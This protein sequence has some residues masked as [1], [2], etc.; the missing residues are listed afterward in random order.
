ML[1]I[2]QVIVAFGIITINEYFCFGIPGDKG[3][4]LGI[5]NPATIATI[6]EIP[7]AKA[8]Y[9]TKLSTSLDPSNVKITSIASDEKNKNVFFAIQN[10]ICVFQNFNIWQNESKAI[11]LSLAY[12]GKSAAFGQI[13]FDFVSNNLYWCDSLLNWIAMK[14][15]YGNDSIHRIVVQDDLYQPEGLA[16]DPEDGLMFFSDNDINPRIEKASMNGENRTVIVHTSIIQILALSVDTANDL[17]YWA[18]H[19]RQTVEVSHYDGSNRRVLRRNN[20]VSLTGI[21]YH[22][23]ILHAA[24]ASS[25]QIFGFDATSGSVLYK[26]KMA[27]AQPFAVH[28]YDA[29]T[30]VSF[31]AP[32]SSRGCQH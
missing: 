28:V 6:T 22:Q 18:D 21:H 26:L 11:T 32:C 31:S 23:N 19:G 16:L 29:E 2:P 10:S 27:F 13:T 8:S 14:P 1:F 5:W 3:L 15:A 30:A 9:F 4:I 7:R 24:S 25:D 12:T 20:Q 17:L